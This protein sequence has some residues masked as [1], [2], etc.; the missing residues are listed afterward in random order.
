MS[1]IRHELRFGAL[2]RELFCY[3]AVF[4]NLSDVFSFLLAVSDV[5]LEFK[6]ALNLVSCSELLVQ[7]EVSTLR[8]SAD[9]D[10]RCLRS[11]CV[12]RTPQHVLESF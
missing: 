9:V 7:V 6:M 11:F 4:D 5:L 2:N 3:E 12:L 8:R 1:L 10:L